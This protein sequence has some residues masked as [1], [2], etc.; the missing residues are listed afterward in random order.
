MTYKN[1]EFRDHNIEVLSVAIL[2]NLAL[3]QK[4]IVFAN[5]AWSIAFAY[6][7]NVVAVVYQACKFSAYTE[8]RSFLR[9]M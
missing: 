4:A 9:V 1:D 7:Q 3:S 5:E 8:V 2:C 6:A